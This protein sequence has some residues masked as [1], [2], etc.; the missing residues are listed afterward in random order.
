MRTPLKV[1]GYC[2]DTITEYSLIGTLCQWVYHDSP[3]QLDNYEVILITDDLK[4][5]NYITCSD[6][7]YP[8]PK[9]DFSEHNILLVRGRTSQTHNIFKNMRQLSA[10]E[11]ILNIEAQL[12]G[13]DFT[14]PWNIAYIIPKS[15]EV[16]VNLI[17]R[18]PFID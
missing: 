7:S 8:Y 4:L 18:N 13:G 2:V 10:N 11:F 6:D 9:I 5:R 1:A 12:T 14:Q 3:Y 16:E 15:S 17:I